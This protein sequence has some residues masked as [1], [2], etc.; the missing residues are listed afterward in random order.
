MKNLTSLVIL[1]MFASR[2]FG[3]LGFFITFI[4]NKCD[5]NFSICNLAIIELHDDNTHLYPH[6]WSIVKQNSNFKT[7]DT[8]TDELD[9][10]R[11]VDAGVNEPYVGPNSS[12][13]LV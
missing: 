12:I 1:S 4:R 11:M 7:S 3:A 6:R 5:K 13:C 9:N 8:L 10:Y 2:V